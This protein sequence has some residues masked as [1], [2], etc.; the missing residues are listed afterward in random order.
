MSCGTAFCSSPTPAI[1][2]HTALLQKLDTK[3]DTGQETTPYLTGCSCGCPVQSSD[4]MREK[5]EAATPLKRGRQ[6]QENT[7]RVNFFKISASTFVSMHFV[8]FLAGGGRSM[9]M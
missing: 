1:S 6:N 8:K 5:H 3:S 9:L 2:C 7:L 4:E